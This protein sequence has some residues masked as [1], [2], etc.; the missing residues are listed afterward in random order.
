MALVGSDSGTRFTALI[1]AR[2]LTVWSAP[3]RRVELNYF[4]F[5]M[6]ILLT[7]PSVCSQKEFCY[8]PLSSTFSLLHNPNPEKDVVDCRVECNLRLCH[9]HRCILYSGKKL[10]TDAVDVDRQ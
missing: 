4:A 10:P 3:Y 8:F 9:L 2:L 6:P 7:C 5:L 1:P